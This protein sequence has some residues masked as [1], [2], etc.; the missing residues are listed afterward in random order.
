MHVE[1]WVPIEHTVTAA[2]DE[3]YRPA[4]PEGVPYTTDNGLPVHLD[5]AR[6]SY[7]HPVNE[8]AAVLVDKRD[9]ER[10]PKRVDEGAVPAKEVALVRLCQALPRERP[11][12]GIEA[13]IDALDLPEADKEELREQMRRR[14]C[15]IRAE[16]EA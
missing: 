16:A 1:V 2:G 14:G 13:D 3:V 15:D 9:V 11:A 10:I 7:G 4:V 12:D 5:P 6:A 8:H